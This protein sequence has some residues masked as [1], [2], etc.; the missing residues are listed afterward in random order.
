MKLS[1]EMLSYI[2]RR[3]RVMNSSGRLTQPRDGSRRK[4]ARSRSPLAL[5]SSNLRSVLTLAFEHP[6]TKRGRSPFMWSGSRTARLRSRLRLGIITSAVSD[7]VRAYLGVS[8]GGALGDRSKPTT[9][10]AMVHPLR[11]ESRPR[12]LLTN[13]AA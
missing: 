10:R 6:K 1:E 9:R 11:F 12:K 13:S 5:R 7:S 2:E 8:N 4:G 3:M